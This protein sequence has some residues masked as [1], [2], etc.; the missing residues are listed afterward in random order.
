MS[1]SKKFK[2]GFNFQ[3]HLHEKK[4]GDG[5]C[6]VIV[7]EHLFLLSRSRGLDRII[8][9]YP[10]G[11]GRYEDNV[12]DD[13]RDLWEMFIAEARECEI[14]VRSTYNCWHEPRWI[15]PDCSLDSELVKGL[16]AGLAR[17]NRITVY[18]N[19]VNGKGDES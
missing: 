13:L 6:V 3:Y 2:I 4:A 12:V 9:G 10:Y 14:D 5:S 8:S 1:K 18:E 15:I 7:E 11:S 17:M 19:G 16:V